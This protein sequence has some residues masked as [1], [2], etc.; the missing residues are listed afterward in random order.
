LVERELLDRKD[1]AFRFFERPLGGRLAT[2]SS[3]RPIQA[4]AD[5]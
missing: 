5:D 3:D 4:F 2:Q 1:V